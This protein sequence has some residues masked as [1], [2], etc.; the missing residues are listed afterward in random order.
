MRNAL[1]RLWNV[2]IVAMLLFALASQSCLPAADQTSTID[3]RSLIPDDTYRFLQIDLKRFRDSP[4]CKEICG[5][6]SIVQF[7]HE[8]AIQVDPSGKWRTDPDNLTTETLAVHTDRVSIVSAS[9][10][11]PD[12]HFLEGMYN[13]DTLLMEFRKV[14][15]SHGLSLKLVSI[16]KYDSIIIEGMNIDGVEK[17]NAVVFLSESLSLHVSSMHDDVLSRVIARYRDK[18]K[19]QLNP[20]M[21]LTM[22]RFQAEAIVA[23][24]AVEPGVSFVGRADFKEKAVF[25]SGTFFLPSDADAEQ[26]EIYAVSGIRKFANEISR[27]FGNLPII[28]SIKSAMVDRS[29]KVVNVEISVPVGDIISTLPLV[30]KQ[31]SAKP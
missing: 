28:K 2:S 23:V 29:E 8:K 20:D 1:C 19:P 27:D 3:V 21:A 25:T 31:L 13:Y 7:I 9:L 14:A 18:T 26:F 16:D 24:A 12:V 5:N 30:L 11:G 15:K 10:F 22:S 17:R 4:H 6:K